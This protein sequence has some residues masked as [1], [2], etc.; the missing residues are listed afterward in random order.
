MPDYS[1]LEFSFFFFV[2]DEIKNLFQILLIVYLDI[3]MSMSDN[4]SDSSDDER[5]HQVSFRR[6]RWRKHQLSSFESRSWDQAK[7]TISKGY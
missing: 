2:Y 3:V 4:Q 7:L 1:V 5:Y 6:S